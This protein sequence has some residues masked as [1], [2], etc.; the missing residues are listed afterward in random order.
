ML[1][2]IDWLVRH[3][4]RSVIFGVALLALIAAYIAIGSGVASVREHFEMD[5]LAFFN[6]WPFKVLIVLLIATLVTVTLQRIPFTPPRWGV[7]MV[8]TGIVMLVGGAAYYYGNKIEGSALMLPGR[9]TVGFYDRWDRALYFQAGG[10]VSKVPLPS[11]PRFHAYSAEQGNGAS[12]D[13]KDLQNLTP[14]VRRADP[15]ANSLGGSGTQVISAAEAV[16]AKT[17]AFT[18][19]GYWPYADIREKLVE[20]P[21]KGV[22]GYKFEL[23]DYG[24]TQPRDRLAAA[25]LPR[26]A[27]AQWGPVDIE[28][29]DLKSQEAFDRLTV[30]VSSMHTLT[31]TW[32]G[33]T[34]AQFVG[35]GQSYDFGDGLSIAVESFDPRW[36]TIDHQIVP[37]LTF[38]VKTPT[39]TFRRMVLSGL[40]RPTD[41][42]L[43]V[44][45]E[46][47]DGAPMGP[48]GKRQK[49][50]LEPGLGTAYIF[51]D[52][53]N[54]LPSGG[55]GKWIFINVAGSNR[56]SLLS[57]QTNGPATLQEFVG[58]EGTFR[59]TE[60]VSE[61]QAM[62]AAFGRPQSP[63]PITL[64]VQRS[65]HA[66]GLTPFLEEV[67]RDLRNR[68]EGSSGRRQVIRVRYDGTDGDGK[69]FTGTALVPFSEHPFEAPWRGGLLE[70]PGASAVAQIQLGN[71]WRPLPAAVKLDK[72]DIQAYGGANPAMN[73][74]IRDYRSTITLTDPQTGQSVTDTVYLNSPVFYQNNYWIFF[75]SQFD[76]QN[77]QWSVL[78]VGNRPGTYTMTIGCCLIV[79]GIF[80]AFYVKPMIIQ[81]MKRKAL[82]KAGLTQK[83]VT[84]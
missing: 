80:Y 3:T 50:L 24:D 21:A 26:Y 63:Q 38:L 5:E 82:A 34:H 4:L 54:L 60:P 77:Q 59:V 78:G 9:T 2:A 20:D 32:A 56:S 48:M 62:M 7:W 52:K 61:E 31:V 23:P 30:D 39:Q 40:D 74:M 36:Q 81:R 53:S 83:V 71:N 72:L 73:A 46:K 65:D 45:G 13:R 64:N 33:K 76:V 27:R 66:A 1:N 47:S 25:A 11:L 37:K 18:I 70:V 22:V 57:V 44:P 75:Q 17:L 67:P 6:A 15:S 29:R 16:G 49:T 68:D 43:A 41:F 35:V 12:L 19:T 14:V 8:H 10:V 69:P 55:L 84:T 51:A 28:A 42:K 79:F 58:S